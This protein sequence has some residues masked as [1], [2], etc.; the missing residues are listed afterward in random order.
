MK[1]TENQKNMARNL[2][3]KPEDY[4]FKNEYFTK[5]S[6]EVEIIYENYQ[7]EEGVVRARLSDPEIDKLMSELKLDPM[8][9][10]SWEIL[11]RMTQ[12]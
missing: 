12:W 1:I 6:T 9:E 7:Y 11:E 3:T 5:P 10:V 2:L 8:E 4:T